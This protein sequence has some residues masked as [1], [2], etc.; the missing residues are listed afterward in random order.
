MKL[1]FITPLFPPQVGGAATYFSLITGELK[2]RGDIEKIVVFST[3]FNGAPPLERD[4]K[5]EIWRILPPTLSA[6]PIP[7]VKV[8]RYIAFLLSLLIT[9]I[10]YNIP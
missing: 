1:L 8:T 6:G 7:I 3:Y 5:M 4:G 9:L 10:A 2:Q